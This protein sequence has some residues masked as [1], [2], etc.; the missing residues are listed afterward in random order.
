M[1]H[2]AARRRVLDDRGGRACLPRLDLGLVVGEYVGDVLGV[3]P[4]HVDGREGGRGVLLDL[5]LG[6]PVDVVGRG[7]QQPGEAPRVGRR[8]SVRG[9][10]AARRLVGALHEDVG[11]PAGVPGG[12]DL[13]VD[14]DAGE[15]R[16][17]GVGAGVR[18]HGRSL[19]GE[20]RRVLHVCCTTNRKAARLG[21][22]SPSRSGLLVSFVDDTDNPLVR[23][24]VTSPVDGGTR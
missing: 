14:G 21:F 11:R 7:E 8:E 15:G 23:G 19:S 17:D 6:G 24:F 5:D 9:D 12:F 16:A 3:P 4:G 10:R 1:S 20:G 22:V 13:D 2:R 18:D